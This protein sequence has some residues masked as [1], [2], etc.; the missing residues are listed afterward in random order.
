MKKYNYTPSS[1]NLLTLLAL[2]R[3]V[4]V[5]IQNVI[6]EFTATCVLARLVSVNIRDPSYILC[7]KTSYITIY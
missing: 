7:F 4:S 3:L 5:N 2:A 6:P 1:R